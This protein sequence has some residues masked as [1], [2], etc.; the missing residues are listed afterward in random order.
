MSNEFKV[1]VEV[2]LDKQLKAEIEHA[3]KAAVLEKLA[4]IDLTKDRLSIVPLPAE[5]GENGNG[6]TDG[7]VVQRMK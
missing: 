2:P 1:I 3:I 7:I 6:T 5:N 4:K